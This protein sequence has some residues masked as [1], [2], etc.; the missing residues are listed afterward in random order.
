MASFEEVI[1]HATDTASVQARL[2]SRILQEGFGPGAWHGADLRAA[3]ANVTPD[4][5][6]W[7]P[8]P[9]RHNIA[10]L[11]LH[12]AYYQRSV[13]E[14]LSG[15]EVE[16]FVVAGP[17][18]NDFFD[19]S[20]PGAPSWPEIQA[21]V[22]TQQERLAALVTDIGAGRV[23]SPLDEGARFDLVLGITCHAVYH[24]GQMQLIKA[25]RG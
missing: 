13:R 2:E 7:R 24:A 21:I 11:A 22:A 8:A 14:R 16:P 19:L 20:S 17:E 12:H 5:A 25:L 9:G 15:T 18:G 10:E 6:S 4:I 3:I 23:T 1:M